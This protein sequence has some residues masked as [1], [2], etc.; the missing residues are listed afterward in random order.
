MIPQRAA[1]VIVLSIILC[2][3]QTVQ[4]RPK[5]GK[6]KVGESKAI[7]ALGEYMRFAIESKEF[8]QETILMLTEE[9]FKE[10]SEL[11]K[12]EG[13]EVKADHSKL[14]GWYRAL[15]EKYP[16]DPSIA[17]LV[18]TLGYALSE[19]G[20]YNGA[21]KTFEIFAENY[22]TSP[23]FTEVCFRLGELYF[24]TGQYGEARDAYIAALRNPNSIFY[25][26]ALYKIGWTYYKL[27]ML[28]EAKD[29][30]TQV[31]D[32]Y[33]SRERQDRM[34]EGLAQESFFNTVLCLARMK[35]TGERRETIEGLKAK[36]YAP[37]LILE[38]GRMLIEETAYEETISIYSLFAT[39]FPEN[40]SLPKVSAEM[41]RAYEWLKEEEKAKELREAIVEKY[42]PA[43][44]WYKK[45]YPDG[46]RELDTLVAEVLTT[47][48]H[49]YRTTG[50]EEK[51]IEGYKRYIAYFPESPAYKDVHLSLAD[52]LFDA[53][54]FREAAAYYITI[55]DMYKGRPEREKAARGAVLSYELIAPEARDGK[56]DIALALGNI[57]DRL[58]EESFS[59]A[60]S[61]D[62]LYKIAAIYTSI[63]LYP[64]A[65][66]LISPH[67]KGKRPS[68]AYQKTGD[69]YIAEGN[70]PKAIDA[71]TSAMRYSNNDK[72]ISSRLS[73]LHNI[74]AA[75][76]IKEER[77]KEAI[78]HYLAV[79][80]IA[81]DPYLAEE[82]LISGG[83]L[84]VK[85]GDMDGFKTVLRS[86]KKS[87]PGSKGTVKLL[88][89]A[90]KLL[91]ERG[92]AIEAVSLFE[93]AATLSWEREDTSALIMKSLA[94]LEEE[95]DYQ[96]IETLLKAYLSKAKLQPHE[97]TG[98]LYMLGVA[99]IISGKKEGIET[100][101]AIAKEKETQAN[102]IYIAKAKLK[103]ADTNLDVFM[104]KTIGIPFEESLKA[105]ESLMKELLGEYTNIIKAAI[106]ELLPE[107]SYKMGLVFENF[108]DSLLDSERPEEL[109]NEDLAEYKFLL[110]EKAYPLEE[111]A[112]SAYDRCIK[113]SMDLNLKKEF[114]QKCIE[115][116]AALRP[117]LY[118]RDIKL[119]ETKPLFMPP[120]PVTVVHSSAK[121]ESI[122]H[123]NEGFD[124]MESDPSEALKS[125]NLALQEEPALYEA[126]YNRGLLLY[127]SKDKEGANAAFSKV[128]EKGEGM[129]E[130]YDAIGM[131]DM[132]DGNISGAIDA[133]KNAVA[134]KNLQR[135]MINLGGIYLM[136]NNIKL[137]I[138]YLR[139]AEKSAADNPYL[140]YNMAL[141]F[142]KQNKINKAAERLKKTVALKEKNPEVLLFVAKVLLLKGDINK[143]I[144]LYNEIV[145]KLPDHPEA[146]RDM[147]IIYELYKKD[148]TKALDFYAKYIA[149]GGKDE[150]AKLWVDL[151]NSKLERLQ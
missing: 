101:M 130:V 75:N 30:F 111:Q 124:K 94:I 129:A 1:L 3:C 27:D 13:E 58:K 140:N 46:N 57:A 38:L 35:D 93:E 39:L 74:M 69:T 128:L 134:V 34:A 23:Y 97:K 76:Y 91:E 37:A 86:I 9:Y 47:L 44:D 33:Q 138:R 108:K 145:E 83:L 143:S 52:T 126:H 42:N 96:H 60:V 114:M 70:F 90:G 43:T 51:A 84:Y 113:A 132:E 12:E 31:V 4:M 25:E 119:P 147:G 92:E 87:Y 21:I 54:N 104:K 100:L 142:L 36:E 17:P 18:Y 151:L 123:F 148:Q 15:G 40:P 8:S 125:F 5:V 116:L 68:L 62:I 105:K 103:L 141:L 28:H 53:K 20:D 133:Y 137:A 65:R 85:T 112:V 144:E 32:R 11:L 66:K 89:E 135:S 7:V 16:D 45:N 19:Q 49:R 55:M 146:Y 14:I 110:E 56:E 2:S 77:F 131:L 81:P 82:A 26:R 41:A 98:M 63:A 118:K 136:E 109:S 120:E 10:H 72:D 139:E 50:N 64:E 117:V 127:R 115:R 61:E 71:Y 122:G 67:L 107:A 59:N 121:K 79:S 149:L 102:R 48:S 22:K 80:S 6:S 24:D 29:Y 78:E 106:S 88:I 150:E 95:E 73:T 99:Q